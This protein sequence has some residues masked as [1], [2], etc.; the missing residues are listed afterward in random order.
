MPIIYN[1]VYTCICDWE[2]R[3]IR[4]TA[5]GET[6]ISIISDQTLE[7]GSPY[8]DTTRILTCKIQIHEFIDESMCLVF[9]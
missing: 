2:H 7:A 4:A 5:L 8:A 1:S 3:S 9:V 6:Y